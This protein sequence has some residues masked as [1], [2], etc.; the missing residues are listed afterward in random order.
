MTLELS[1]GVLHAL[2]IFAWL[3]SLPIGLGIISGLFWLVTRHAGI[4][5]YLGFAVL[6]IT[7]PIT[8]SRRDALSL[9][10]ILL[11]MLTATICLTLWFK[12]PEFRQLGAVPA[13]VLI[14]VFLV[15]AA[16]CFGD[17]PWVRDV[18][19]TLA[20]R[21]KLPDSPASGAVAKAV[22]DVS[23]GNVSLAS[24]EAP[25]PAVTKSVHPDI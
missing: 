18:I 25:T 14:S 12:F 7:N 17:K 5:Q 23:G 1:P 2:S 11:F 16:Y 9:G 24:Y 3:V 22:S 10:R 20:G 6:W 4:R 13:S 19:L 21:A 8:N 15:L